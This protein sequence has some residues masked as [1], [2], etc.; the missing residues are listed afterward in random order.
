MG[1]VIISININLTN[2]DGELESHP[3]EVEAVLPED[4]SNLID[5]VEKAV[6]ELNKDVIRQAVSTYLEE[7]SKKKPELSKDIEEA[8]SKQGH[9]N[10]E[11][12]EK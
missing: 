3:I 7:V 12:T 10:T 6:L 8:L 11:S 2:L 9:Q 4:G 5:N 1:T